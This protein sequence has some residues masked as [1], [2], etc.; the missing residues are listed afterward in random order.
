MAYCANCG[1]KLADGAKFCAECGAKSAGFYSNVGANPTKPAGENVSGN[2]GAH[3]NQ[4]SYTYQ[5]Q[6]QQEQKTQTYGEG[7]EDMFDPVDVKR[8]K[9]MGVLSYLG[10]LVLIPILAGDKKSYYVKFHANQGLA[11]FLV[12]IGVNLIS[13]LTRFIVYEVLGY[14]RFDFFSNIFNILEFGIFI[15]VIMGIVYACKG[16]KRGF[17]FIEDIKILK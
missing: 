4:Q 10:I 2:T 6:Y 8:N 3:E 11:L 13:S 9:V 12:S 7:T 17:P 16:E 15:L 14:Y 1:V 5:Y